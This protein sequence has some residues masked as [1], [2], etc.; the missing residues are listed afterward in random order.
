MGERFPQPAP[1]GPKPE[2]PPPP[3]LPRDREGYQ[4]TEAL[5]RADLGRANLARQEAQAE[6]AKLRT[7]NREL[8]N[9]LREARNRVNALE[10]ERRA[11]AMGM[12]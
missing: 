9:E 8:R 7:E 4:R 1:E 10:M 2:S 5:L 12:T 3:P 6:A 11:A